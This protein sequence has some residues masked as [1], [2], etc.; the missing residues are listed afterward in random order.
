MRDAGEQNRQQ[1]PRQDDRYR[2]PERNCEHR[3]LPLKMRLSIAR[4]NPRWQLSGLKFVVLGIGTRN[5][6]RFRV[7]SEIRVT[8]CV[9]IHCPLPPNP[10]CVYPN[11]ELLTEWDENFP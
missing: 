3:P 8:G 9:I 1:L 7:A 4:R 5:L 6:I 11:L 10:R 2:S